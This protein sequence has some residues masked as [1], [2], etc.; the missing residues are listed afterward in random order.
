MVF[1]QEYIERIDEIISLIKDNKIIDAS[2]KFREYTVQIKEIGN[3]SVENWNLEWRKRIYLF[4]ELFALKNPDSFIGII[5][6]QMDLSSESEK[7]VLLFIKSEIIWNYFSP[8]ESH[9]KDEFKNCTKIYPFNPEFFHSYSHVLMKFK[10]YDESLKILEHTIRLEETN[11]IF[12]ETFFHYSVQ[13]SNHY[14]EK[15]DFENAKKFLK[16]PDS[17]R[18]INFVQQNL[19]YSMKSRIEDNERI[20]DRINKIFDNLEKRKDDIQWR[21]IEILGIFSSILALIL[22]NSTI[23]TKVEEFSNALIFSTTSSLITIGTFSM[24]IG[25]QRRRFD[26]KYIWITASSFIIVCIIVYLKT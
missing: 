21:L 24:L 1:K 12:K 20:H 6:E 13:I 9:I 16:K 11:T 23:L 18:W 3:F 7:E 8:L 10:N 25:M 4:W 14:L 2:S 17:I 5:K 15:N 19:L 26:H 22:I